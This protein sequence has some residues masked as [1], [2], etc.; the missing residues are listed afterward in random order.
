M[1]LP[2]FP[3]SPVILSNVLRKYLTRALRRRHLNVHLSRF[4]HFAPPHTVRQRL[5]DPA[6]IVKSTRYA[7]PWWPLRPS[8]T[9]SRNF[10]RGVMSSATDI[11]RERLVNR[12][13]ESTSPYVSHFDIHC[14]GVLSCSHSL[15][16]I[17]QRQPSGMAGMERF[18]LDACEKAR[19][20][21]LL[22][23]RV[24]SLSLSVIPI[25]TSE[26]KHF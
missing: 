11:H 3:I 14:F 13:A 20:P 15:G 18:H 12:L 9:S 1:S 25:I 10:Q 5:R 22:E 16:P 2:K 23:H 4:H 26:L 8:N 21:N 6:H 24:L 17:A 19:P 7:G